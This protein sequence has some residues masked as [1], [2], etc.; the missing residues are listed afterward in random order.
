MYKFAT[1][2]EN[3]E[4]L[5]SGR[6]LHGAPGA[7]NF[8]V[9]LASEIFQRC[10]SLLKQDGRK[11]PYTVYDPLCGAGY[12]L[13]VLGFLHGEHIQRLVGSDYDDEILNTARQNLNLL[14]PDGLQAR[15]ADLQKLYKKHSRPSH[16]D[17]MDSA[18]RL[19]QRLE[20]NAEIKISVFHQNALKIDGN[21]PLFASV[22]ITLVDLPYGELTQ[23]K[24][25]EEDGDATHQL[26]EGLIEHLPNAGVIAVVSNQKLAVQ[27]PGL[28]RRVRFKV[29]KRH[30]VLLSP[31]RQSP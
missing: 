1:K 15:A 14:S 3:F 25:Q 31:V 8:P 29:G 28:T 26:L 18:E 13:T 27:F 2:R 4:D 12:T 17:A 19:R 7:T 21:H 11:P 22:D 5:S 9:R 23:W 30:V 24:G 20:N 10:T 16:L 6:V